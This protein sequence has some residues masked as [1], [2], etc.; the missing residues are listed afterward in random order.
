[1]PLHDWNVTDGWDGVHDIW[2]VELLRQIKPQLPA[3]YRAH[4]GT[5]PAIS[6]DSV[7]TKPDVSIRHWENGNGAPATA[8]ATQFVE[9]EH[10]VATLTVDPDKALMVTY[11]G[12]LVAVIEIVSPRNK[13]RASSRS[14]YLSRYLGYVGSLVNLMIVD[15]HAHPFGF[16]FADAMN[17]EL[18]LGQTPLPSPMCIAY[19]VGEP[20]PDGGSFVATWRRPLSIGQPLP[21]LPLS[22][23]VFKQIQIDLET[24]YSKAAADAYLT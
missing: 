23:S 7:N 1:M 18:K 10:E 16:S 2:L 9:P 21:T 19:R 22:L 15:V 8:P 6:I 4:I 17:D 24:T 12:Q 5:V 13:D 3:D 14:K 11:R 20:A